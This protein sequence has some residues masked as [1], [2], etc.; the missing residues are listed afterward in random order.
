MMETIALFDTL[1]FWPI[2]ENG[3]PSKALATESSP[4]VNKMRSL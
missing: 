1:M 3:C 4:F 2:A